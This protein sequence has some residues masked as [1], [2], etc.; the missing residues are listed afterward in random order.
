MPLG[1]VLLLFLHTPN[2]AV[3]PVSKTII[4]QTNTME[5]CAHSHAFSVVRDPM[6]ES[7]FHTL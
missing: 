6:F 5:F 3:Y 1:L 2:E 7:F 4:V